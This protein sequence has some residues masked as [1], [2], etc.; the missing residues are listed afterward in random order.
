MPPDQV[1]KVQLLP[2]SACTEYA[3][4]AV[5]ANLVGVKPDPTTFPL[6]PYRPV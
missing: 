4:P 3:N 6:E 1:E 5:V 2:L